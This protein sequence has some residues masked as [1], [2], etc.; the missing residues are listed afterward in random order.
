MKILKAFYVFFFVGLLVISC[1][2]DTLEP[3]KDISDPTL[4]FAVPDVPAD[5]ANLMRV[6]DLTRF[7]AGP[8]ESYLQRLEQNNGRRSYGRWHPVLMKLG[9]H[10]QFGPFVGECEFPM[11]CYGPTGPTGATG[12]DDPA[13]FKGL[14]GLA[15]ADG[16]WFAKKLHSEYY[17]V[18]CAADDYAGYGQGF[19]ALDDGT[20]WFQGESGPHN[21]D[22]AGNMVFCTE[23][24]FIRE[25]CTENYEGAF[26][27]NVLIHYTTPENN[28]GNNNGIGYSD[29]IIFGWVYY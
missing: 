6:D 2:K 21:Y 9:Y 15:T 5:I 1:Q 12:C 13:K 24:N 16:Y 29:V 25:Q 10:L 19:Y 17:P 4:E 22:E 28:P 26:G 27:W 8:G 18:F 11:P 20:L 14:A 23:I 7:Q 3:I